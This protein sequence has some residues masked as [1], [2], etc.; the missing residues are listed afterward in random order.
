MEAFWNEKY[1]TSEYIYGIQIGAAI[2][3]YYL[4]YNKIKQIEFLER[5]I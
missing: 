1:S 4:I 5:K 3:K 2:I